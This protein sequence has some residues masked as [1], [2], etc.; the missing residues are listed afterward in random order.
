MLYIV[1]LDTGAYG[2]F[3][4]RT[5]T[6]ATKCDLENRKSLKLANLQYVCVNYLPWPLVE[7]EILSWG[8]NVIVLFSLRENIQLLIVAAASA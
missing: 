2:V 1:V 8:T 4:H 3:R 7:V 5:K 6:Y